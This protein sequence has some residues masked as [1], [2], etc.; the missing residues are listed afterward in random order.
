MSNLNVTALAYA[1]QY[2]ND[3]TMARISK[4]MVLSEIK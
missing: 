1:A 2:I 3:K 4:T